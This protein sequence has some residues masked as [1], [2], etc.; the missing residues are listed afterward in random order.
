MRRSTI[1]RQAQRVW[2]SD[3]YLS[4]G[5]IQG[6]HEHSRAIL[7]AQRFGTGMRA[8]VILRAVNN[9]EASNASKGAYLILE[10]EN[11]Q[12]GRVTTRVNG[13]DRAVIDSTGVALTGNTTISSGGLDVNSG[14]LSHIGGVLSLGGFGD[15]VGRIKPAGFHTVLDN[16]T[17]GLGT[18]FGFLFVTNSTNGHGALYFLRGTAAV[19]LL[20]TNGTFS[21]TAGT[22]SSNNIY[23]DG[24]Q[25]RIENKRGA[26][27]SYHVIWLGLSNSF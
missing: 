27:V 14:S 20:D 17:L 11:G 5:G 10:E 18:G 25:W 21:I 16:G 22:A 15:N 26:N 12:T 24:S 6:T 8:S 7:R 13:I 9:A 3:L 2:T 23:W 4:A 1:F 19:E